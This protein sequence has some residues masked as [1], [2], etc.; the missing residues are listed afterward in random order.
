MCLHELSRKVSEKWLIKVD[1]EEYEELV[2]KWFDNRCPYC[3]CDLA[4]AVSVIEHLDG[5]NRYRAGL[6]TPGKNVT[7]KSVATIR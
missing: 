1:G 2:R 7:A 4:D 3:S 5:M 6:H